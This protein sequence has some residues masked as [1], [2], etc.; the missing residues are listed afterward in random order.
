MPRGGRRPGAGRPRKNVTTAGDGSKLARK[1]KVAPLD[2]MLNVVNDDKAEP[3]RRDRMA[4]AAAQYMHAKVGETGKKKAR[5][6]AAKKASG[7][8]APP[9]APR[10]ASVR[11][12]K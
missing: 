8:F 3:K 9:T 1:H 2:Y 5:D 12:L 10:L 7:K 4:I 6:D 11:P